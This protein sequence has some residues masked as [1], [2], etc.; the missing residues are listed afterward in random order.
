MKSA[1]GVPITIACSKRW[2]L[3]GLFLSL[4]RPLVVITPLHPYHLA[5][6]TS[7]IGTSF[8][9]LQR[10]AASRNIRTSN[11]QATRAILFA[12]ATDVATVSAV[13]N[14]FYV[15]QARGFSDYLKSNGVKLVSENGAKSADTD[16][17]ALSTKNANGLGELRTG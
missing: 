17:A 8:F 7:P 3:R 10:P 13:D 16:F 12:N 6:L 15:L 14:E 1:D 2:T 4:V 11:A 5:E 9:T